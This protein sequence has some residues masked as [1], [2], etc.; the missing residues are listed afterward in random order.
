MYVKHAICCKNTLF[1]TITLTSR[2]IRNLRRM[3]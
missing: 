1:L 3:V 2:R